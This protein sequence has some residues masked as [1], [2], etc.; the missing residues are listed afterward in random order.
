MAFRG[1]LRGGSVIGSFIVGNE[2]KRGGVSVV[3]AANFAC[4]YGVSLPGTPM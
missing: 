2:M 4:L 1:Q 3:A